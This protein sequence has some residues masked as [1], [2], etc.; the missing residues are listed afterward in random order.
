[1]DFRWLRRYG[2]LLLIWAFVMPTWAQ[3][4]DLEAHTIVAL[5]AIGHELLLSGDDSSTRVLPIVAEDEYYEIQ[6]D[7]PFD[8]MPDTLIQIIAKVVGQYQIA[9]AYLVETIQAST[10]EIVHAYEV[11]AR[12]NI[13]PC[14]G[15]NYTRDQYVIRF[16]ILQGPLYVK[17][18]ATS[19]T[20]PFT[21][22]DWMVLLAVALPMLG[23]ILYFWQKRPPVS[24]EDHRLQ[25]GQ[26]RFDPQKM[27][28]SLGKEEVVLTG[29]ESELL[30]LLHA[31]ANTT[32]ARERILEIVWGDEGNYVG[33]TLDVFI[34]KLRK[35]LAADPQ[36][37]IANIRGVGYK[38]IVEQ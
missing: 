18:A 36:V 5:R 8:L 35:K 28:L 21:T 20:T 26:Y 7:G 38:L 9:A 19:S 16:R 25:I 6:F 14:G 10:G 3:D 23:L 4:A 27:M 13:L 15:R 11:S 30:R 17:N 31:S 24:S 2:L 1:M 22:N 29:K 37:S 34:S 33:R 32:L 12:S